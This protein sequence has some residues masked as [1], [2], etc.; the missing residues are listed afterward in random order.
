MAQQCGSAVTHCYS[1]PLTHPRAT[2]AVAAALQCHITAAL[3]QY[4]EV[5]TNT[6]CVYKVT[7][8]VNYTKTYTFTV[9]IKTL[10]LCYLFPDGKLKR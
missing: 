8:L 7:V 9:E 6:V 4:R 10:V 2:D 1:K 3:I 5:T